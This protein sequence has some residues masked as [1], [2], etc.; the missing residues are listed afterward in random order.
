MQP[1]LKQ[2]SSNPNLVVDIAFVE[3]LGMVVVEDSFVGCKCRRVRVL[4]RISAIEGVE[5]EEEGVGSTVE[6][7]GKG[8]VAEIQLDT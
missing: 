6:L 7:Q 8:S 5:T 4:E 1:V 2:V 3:S